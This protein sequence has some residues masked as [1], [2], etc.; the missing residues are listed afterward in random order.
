M[1]AYRKVAQAVI[2][3]A[4]TDLVKGTAHAE[5]AY[6]FLCGVSDD[7]RAMLE[8]WCSVAGYTHRIR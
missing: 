7:N 8:F 1:Q 3:R 5:E 4:V 6:Q 2:A